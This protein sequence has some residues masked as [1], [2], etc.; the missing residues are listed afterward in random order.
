MGKKKGG[1]RKGRSLNIVRVP[2]QQS[3]LGAMTAGS[4][5]TQVIPSALGGSTGSVYTAFEFYRFTR[6][7]YCLLPR[8]NGTTDN[9]ITLAY[10]P[11]VNVT[12]P[13][14]INAA[15]ENMDAIIQMDTATV[16]TRWHKVPPARL[17]GQIPWYKCQPDASAT[18]FEVQGIIQAFGTGTETVY[19]VFR[20]VVEF[21]TPVD[22]ATAIKRLKELARAEFLSEMS[23]QI[24]PFRQSAS[25]VKIAAPSVPGM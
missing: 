2:F 15:M 1:K 3:I 20:G 10:Y 14:S 17:K 11:D 22:S 16:P 7:E 8:P 4:L 21:R 24:S 19:A 13:A 18:D 25:V 5:Q 6:L 12:A 9:P 23:T